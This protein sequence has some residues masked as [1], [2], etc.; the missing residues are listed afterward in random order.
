[1]CDEG[2]ECVLHQTLIELQIRQYEC[3]SFS[4]HMADEFGGEPGMLFSDDVAVFGFQFA[5]RARPVA[6]VGL[7]QFPYP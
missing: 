6:L 7:V 1:M 3:V 2:I 5:E 4:E